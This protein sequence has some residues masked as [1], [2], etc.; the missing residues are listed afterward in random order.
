M[1]GEI[2]PTTRIVENMY[3]LHNP[4]PRR[5]LNSDHVL[6]KHQSRKKTRKVR[7]RTSERVQKTRT[8]ASQGL[9]C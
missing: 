9:T 5:S 7:N 6:L 4:F 1:N 2:D 8:K 3:T